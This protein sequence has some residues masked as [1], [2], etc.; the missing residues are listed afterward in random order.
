MTGSIVGALMGTYPSTR[1]P[2]LKES[3]TDTLDS[4]VR[5]IEHGI[6]HEAMFIL[7]VNGL[8][9]EEILDVRTLGGRTDL[10]EVECLPY[11]DGTGKKTYVVDGAEGE[12][13]KS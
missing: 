2:S 3:L 5:S 12:A 7:N 10:Y 13:W 4:G 11:L 6:R 8:S 9:C 1:A